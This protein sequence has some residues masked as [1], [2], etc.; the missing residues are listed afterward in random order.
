MGSEEQQERLKRYWTAENGDPLQFQLEALQLEGSDSNSLVISSNPYKGTHYA[1][2]YS[3]SSYTPKVASTIFSQSSRRSNAASR[4][5]SGSSE[6]TVSDTPY[7][8][9]YDLPCEFGASC[10]VRFHGLEFQL[11]VAHSVFHFASS[12]SQT[13]LPPPK[14]VCI[15][16][17]ELFESPSQSQ[18]DILKTWGLRME[19][20]LT[21]YKS[22]EPL[23]NSRPDFHV[24]DH[25]WSIGNIS[26][27]DYEEAISYSE[28]PAHFNHPELVPL[29]T[30]RPKTEKM[31][32]R[33]K[34]ER[35]DKRLQEARD[36]EKEERLLKRQRKRNK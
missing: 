14:S 31:R 20:I 32:E 3:V 18:D 12:H 4:T 9:G 13:S 16:C 35:K 27:H 28:R 10:F 6:S 26:R 15:F 19:H 24:I 1:N 7:D 34:E 2:Q 30:K 33:K 21:H 5:F 8:C 29:G 22:L 36:F 23:E 11:W 25:L 17:D